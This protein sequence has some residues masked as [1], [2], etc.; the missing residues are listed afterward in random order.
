M[1]ELGKQGDTGFSKGVMA[2]K[3]MQRGNEK[4]AKALKHEVEDIREKL[5]E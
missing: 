2:L 1:E 4:D 5:A 3:F